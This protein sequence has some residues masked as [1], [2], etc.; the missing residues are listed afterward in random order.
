MA[1]VSNHESLSLECWWGQTGYYQPD[2]ADWAEYRDWSDSLPKRGPDPRPEP[3][4]SWWS[5]LTRFLE[6][7]K[8]PAACC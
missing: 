1:I 8:Q 7:D 4:C 3:G 6:A 5:R 2:E